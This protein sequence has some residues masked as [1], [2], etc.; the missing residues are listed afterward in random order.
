[1]GYMY[2][3]RNLPTFQR[4]NLTAL[5]IEAVS[6]S[7]TRVNLYDITEGCHIYLHV[8]R[9]VNQKTH[10][11]VRIAKLHFSPENKGSMSMRSSGNC[12][13]STWRHNKKGKF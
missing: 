7:E 3:Y 13:K 5:M 4:C 1:M 12:I 8:S 6:T 9:S 11:Q 2:S 10:V